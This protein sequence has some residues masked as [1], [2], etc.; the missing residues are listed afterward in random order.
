M[1]FTVIALAL[2]A[3]LASAGV[4]EERLPVCS[5][6]GGPCDYRQ[7][8]CCTDQRLYCVRIRPIKRNKLGGI[9]N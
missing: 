3:G 9:E 8:R 5:D 7:F 1:K 4:L 2:F 6:E